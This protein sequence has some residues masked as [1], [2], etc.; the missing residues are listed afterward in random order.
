MTTIRSDAIRGNATR[1]GNE[2]LFTDACSLIDRKRV[3]LIT[4]QSGV[5]GLLRSTAERLSEWPQSELIALF[6][7]EHGIRGD[8]QDGGEV[9][10]SARDPR[11]GV[12]VHSLYGSDGRKPAAD[13]LDCLDVL[14]F[15]IQDVGVRFYTYLYTMSLAMEACAERSLPFIVLDRPNPLGGEVLE[16]NVLDP[17]FASFVGKYPIPVRY[18]MTIGEL[19]GL[20]N[21]EYALGAELHVVQ[22]DGWRRSHWWNDSGL[23]WV[24]P[25]PNMPTADTVLV[26]P[27]TC[28]VEGTNLSEG[29][30]TTRPFEQIGA[31]YV[32]GC[33][34]AD[35][36]N[37]RQL[38]GVRFR[39]VHFIPFSGKYAN[40][41]CGGVQ[42]HVCDRGDF[43][44]VSTGFQILSSVKDR[45]PGDFEWRIPATGI[46][47]FDKLAGA[48][49]IR[50]SLDVGTEIDQLTRRWNAECDEFARIRRPYLLYNC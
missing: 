38:P 3:G 14:L 2:R 8:H 39:P 42:L 9:S 32:D 23:H 35:E 28:F 16:G 20:M 24:P 11:T 50:L 22:M 26:Y 41:S 19:A 40:Q 1:L 48:D 15:D 34:L 13:L 37:E 29:R 36:L 30:G 7:P 33:W 45:W 5:D 4:N 6:S 46:H 18:A 49:T 47:N 10:S 27:G 21:R 43:R 25:S 17:S 12:A 44:P 31:P